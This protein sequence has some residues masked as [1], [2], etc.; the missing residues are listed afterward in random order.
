MLAIAG[1][2]GGCGKTTTALGL[3]RALAGRN[4]TPLVVDADSDMPDV[5]HIV[6][7]PPEPGIDQCTDGTPL[8][9]VTR[10]TDRFPGVRVLT[11]GRREHLDAA[12]RAVQSWPGPV[13]VDCPPGSGPDAT[14]PLRH[15][16]SAVIVTT[17]EPACL[18]DAART[19]RTTRQL[20]VGP[21][22]VLAVRLRQGD[23]P[24]AV[25]GCRILAAVPFVSDPYANG[26]VREA[27]QR[28]AGRLTPQ[29]DVGAARADSGPGT[30]RS[31]G[32]SGSNAGGYTPLDGPCGPETGFFSL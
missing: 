27:W 6:D 8:D 12:L 22:G 17:D 23:L 30:R 32:S 24:A 11:G 16:E 13:L 10:E 20:G 5:H 25:A 28:V 31:G 9:T 26:R 19:V 4:R 14:R 18:E 3:A 21:A 29:A 15:A 7:L 1:G 2:K